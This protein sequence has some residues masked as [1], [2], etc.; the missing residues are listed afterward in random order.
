MFTF[1]VTF[2]IFPGP[3]FTKT[4][5]SINGT[6]SVIIF[7]LVYNIGD[8]VGKY[9]AEIKGIFN[10]K[11][12]I[13]LTIARIIFIYPVTFMAMKSD[14]GDDLTDNVVFPFVNNLLFAIT[15]GFC[16]NA[17][18]ILA[19][20]HCPLVY[21]KYAGVLCGL[22]LQLGIILGTIIEVPYAYIFG[23]NQ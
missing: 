20:Q 23:I 18:F 13:Y 2:T 17:S 21:K 3:I 14:I 1:V 11:S 8:T 19:F 15:N 16:I 5:D 9:G 10:H 6:W 12:V 22:A 7:N 4:F